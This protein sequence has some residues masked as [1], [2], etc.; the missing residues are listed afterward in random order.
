[1]FTSTDENSLISP[2][3]RVSKESQRNRRSFV[4][5]TKREVK[6]KQPQGFPKVIP[7]SSWPLPALVLSHK[8]SSERGGAFFAILASFCL[9]I[10][11]SQWYTGDIITLDPSLAGALPCLPR[12]PSQRKHLFIMEIMATGDAAQRFSL[13]DDDGS[14]RARREQNPD[15]ILFTRAPSHSLKAIA[16]LRSSL[17]YS[18]TFGDRFYLAPQNS[19]RSCLRLVCIYTYNMYAAVPCTSINSTLAVRMI[20]RHNNTHRASKHWRTCSFRRRDRSLPTGRRGSTNRYAFIEVSHATA[21]TAATARATCAPH[22]ISM[23]FCVARAVSFLSANFVVARRGSARKEAG[24]RKKQ[25]QQKEKRGTRKKGTKK[26][27]L[28]SRSA[29]N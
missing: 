27:T 1:M 23:G 4:N 12:H 6:L 14:R 11:S 26:I 2:F 21:A 28:P 8:R 3:L 18:Q 24:V 5:K 29:G 15:A 7:R 13:S 19:A 25:Q 10:I 16:A 20:S 17:L 9:C 22:G